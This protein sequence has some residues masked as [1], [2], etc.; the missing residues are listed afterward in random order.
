MEIMIFFSPSTCI[1]SDGVAVQILAVHSYLSDTRERCVSNIWGS[2]WMFS[3]TMVVTTE[4]LKQRALCVL[5][6]EATV[7]GF[8]VNESRIAFHQNDLKIKYFDGNTADV[9]RKPST[10]LNTVVR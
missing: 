4:I 1:C 6:G 3:L 8:S 7:T 10:A 9:C 2:C 5:P